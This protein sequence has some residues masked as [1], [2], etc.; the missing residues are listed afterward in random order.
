MMP[1]CGYYDYIEVFNNRSRRHN[2]LGCVSL[3]AFE[4]ASA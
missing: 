1:C 3:D 4:Q 2:R